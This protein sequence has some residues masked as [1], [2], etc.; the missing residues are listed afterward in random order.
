LTVST[1]LRILI[2]VAVDD[3]ETR[4]NNLRRSVEM[5]KGDSR[6]TLAIRLWLEEA[7]ISAAT[8]LGAARSSR[9]ARSSKGSSKGLK[10]ADNGDSRSAP[11]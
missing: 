1:S 6:D 4:L 9:A 5:L 10:Q 3:P 7:A 11:F 2:E 8:S